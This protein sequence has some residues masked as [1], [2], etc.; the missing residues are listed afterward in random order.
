MSDKPTCVLSWTHIRH[1]T[2]VYVSVIRSYRTLRVGVTDNALYSVCPQA[3]TTPVPARRSQRVTE[4]LSQRSCLEILVFSTRGF[5]YPC[6]EIL[7]FSTRC[8]GYPSLLYINH[9]STM[10]I[11]SWGC[12]DMRGPAVQPPR[13]AHRGG[14]KKMVLQQPP[15]RARVGKRTP[16]QNH[17][18]T[19]RSHGIRIKPVQTSMKRG[20]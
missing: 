2:V 14:G 16:Y 19:Q 7:V 6:L 13:K 12:R 8:I 1:S 4:A 15:T 9:G 5:G 18:E 17:S 11:Q 10:C 20:Q 3:R